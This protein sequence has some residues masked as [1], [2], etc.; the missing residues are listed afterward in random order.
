MIERV[1]I[2]AAGLG[3]RLLT[4][5]K[6]Q[7]KE[8]LPIFDVGSNH[9]LVVKP[10]IQMIFEQLYDLGIREFFFIVGRGKRALED[11]FTPDYNYVEELVNRGKDEL[12]NE[13]VEFYRRVEGSVITWVNQPS[14][15]GFGHAVL[16]FKPLAKKEPFL[17]HAGDTYIASENGDHVMR[18]I[19]SFDRSG[20]S[21]ALLLQRVE[22]PKEYGV[23]IVDDG[24]GLM[25]V[26]RVVEKPKVPPSNM[27]IM[28]IYVFE[29]EI[30][31]ALEGIGP[32]VGG[33]LQLTDG[34]QKLIEWG[35]RVIAVRLKDDE[36]RLDV[37]NPQSYWEALRTSYDLSRD[38]STSR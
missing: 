23:A 1:L 21:A 14:P 24:E 11:H 36:V 37:G 3:S 17:V 35:K 38:K 4:V 5:T 9:R 22:D 20:C 13:L 6:E 31:R 12:A 33:E 32:G 7:P 2:P 27:A 25:D 10:T 29:Y 30:F 16:L 28:P 15:L 34:I 26:R 18:L 19:K 8:M